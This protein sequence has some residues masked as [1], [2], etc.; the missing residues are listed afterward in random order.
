VI[1]F[2]YTPGP[3]FIAFASFVADGTQL[4]PLPTS[5][6]GQTVQYEQIVIAPGNYGWFYFNAGGQGVCP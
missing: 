4:T 3:T 2:F 1:L 5:A 6:T